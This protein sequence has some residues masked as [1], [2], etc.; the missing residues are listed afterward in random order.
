MGGCANYLADGCHSAA[1]LGAPADQVRSGEKDQNRDEQIHRGNGEK[2]TGLCVCDMWPHRRDVWPFQQKKTKRKWHIRGRKSPMTHTG[3]PVCT[4]PDAA[5]WIHFL[6]RA[7]G[8]IDSS[9]IDTRLK[10]W[11]K[12]ALTGLG[13]QYRLLSSVRN[14]EW[15]SVGVRR[16]RR[17]LELEVQRSSRTIEPL[18]GKTR[19]HI[20]A[21]ESFFF[22]S[23]FNEKL[24]QGWSVVLRGGQ[25][26]QA[27][28]LRPKLTGSPCY[29]GVKLPLLLWKRL[30]GSRFSEKMRCVYVLRAS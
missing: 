18:W 3:S 19:S 5:G 25:S 2:L 30:P 24:L 22:F 1:A 29:T 11:T 20:S 15:E 10:N 17:L 26:T 13:E 8:S 28:A 21:A 7:D 23:F 12:Q 9:S 14:V 6:F 16:A 27:D 4:Q